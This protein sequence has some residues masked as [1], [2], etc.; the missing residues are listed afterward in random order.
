M[1]K[2]ATSIISIVLLLC[3]LAG[4]SALA[5]ES[6]AVSTQTVAGTS[7]N[8]GCMSDPK[9]FSPWNGG[10][11]GRNM[12]NMA[13]YETLAY[14]KA[15]GTLSYCIMK[16]Y[17]S[18]SE[19]VYDITIYDY[20]HDS[21][22]NPITADDIV[23][24]FESCAAQGDWATYTASMESITKIDDYTVEIVMASERPDSFSGLLENVMIVSEASYTA[25]EDAMATWP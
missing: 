5:T 20:V 7:L 3:L 12:L 13:V 2:L 9:T 15:D 23:F 1:K 10:G 8:F 17:S 4:S 18:P 6:A 11:G 25:S 14:M 16:E 24:S 19:G 22:G 21:A